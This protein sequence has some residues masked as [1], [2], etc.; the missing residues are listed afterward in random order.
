[1]SRVPVVLQTAETDCGPAC[2]TAM[3][4][5]QGQRVSLVDLRSDMDPGR[6]GSSGV[7][8]RR[9]A[10][11]WG[12]PLQ[13]QLVDPAEL[14]ERID[15]LPLPLILHLKRQ[16]YVI[17]DRV[18]GDHVYVMDPAVGRRRLTRDEL[19]EEISGV[20]LYLGETD[21]HDD[22]QRVPK[23]LSQHTPGPKVLSQL[24]GSVRSDLARAGVLSLLLA[25][26]GIALPVTT[27]LI[28][29]ALVASAVDPHYWLIIGMSLAVTIG[30]LTWGRTWVLATLQRRMAARL[31]TTV[32]DTLFSR[33][34]KF[35]DRRSVGDL[36][37][38]VESAHAIHAL[39]GVA[40]LGAGL[41]A[42]LTIGY[43]IALV[44][45]A[46]P[47]AAVTGC[48][49][50][51]SLIV[52]GLIA[53]RS[54]SLRR[55]EILVTAESSTLLVDGI[56]GI[57]TLRAYD[58][59]SAMLE[60][61]YQLLDRRLH[62]TRSRA[63]LNAVSMALLAAM[64]VGA[65][66]VILVLAS[67]SAVAATSMFGQITP[68]TALGFMALAAATLTP[69][70]SLATQLVEAA[71]LRPLL[72]RIK[73][74]TLAEPERS[75]GEDPGELTGQLTLQD[76]RFKH[77]RYG[78][79][80]LRG[81]NAHVAAGSTICVLGPTGCGKTT[82]AQVMAGMHSP[83]AGGVLVDGKD[84]ATLDPQSLRAQIGVV[85]Q[86]SWTPAG[87]IR[88]AILVSR[89]GYTDEDIWRALFHAQLAQEVLALP[90]GLD[91]RLGSGGTGLSGGQRQRLA[92]ARAL[93]GEPKILILDEPTSALDGDTERAIETALVELNIT[94]IIVT[95]RLSIATTADQLWIMDDGELVESGSPAE[96]ALGDGW[97]AQLLQSQ[98]ASSQKLTSDT[99]LG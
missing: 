91:T 76:V 9:T 57:T 97:Y 43:L 36:F 44:I 21:E 66:L 94:R 26:G 58:A 30:V 92:L 28:V 68:G 72:E 40:L 25:V 13:A 52:S 3:L 46:P 65:P 64:G 83:T 17:V 96:L 8:M 79:E 23:P 82:L 87:T 31:S 63:R 74:L 1:M 45:I 37:G 27:A 93:L 29:D 88:D 84:L 38:R 70:A 5:W 12:L 4:R 86:D 81:I 7:V 35:F 34:L 18:R 90:M 10:Q 53:K 33:S 73:D 2:L 22:E 54:A 14:A 20:L 85:F 50:A 71:D 78:Q 80:I 16:H 51:V 77:E 95:H 99:A 55:E 61:W 89:T 59:E 49:A 15:E 67:S 24:L 19:V 41:D 47:L 32:A 39:L 98:S 62:L 56:D 60:D 69:V 6:D 42:L 48:F 75:D 11:R